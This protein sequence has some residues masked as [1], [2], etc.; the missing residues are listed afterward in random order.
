[1]TDRTASAA[2]S[3][4]RAVDWTSEWDVAFTHVK[5]RR[6]LFREYLRRA[7]L[8]ARAYGA[9]GSRPFFDATSYMDPEYR[10]TPELAA[11]LADFL[12]RLPNGEVR[13][14]CSGVVRTAGLRERN[15]AA[16]SD[17]P[18]LYEPLVLFYER[19]GEFTRDNAGFLDLT[20]VRFRPG[21]LESHLGNPPVTLLG[22]T[23]LDA[24][25]ADGQVMYHTAEGRRGP[26]FR[27]RVLRGEQS[28]E[29]F[30]RDLCWEP[31]DLIPGTGAEA[32]E[33]G[34]VRLEELEAAGLIGEIVAA[35]TR[36]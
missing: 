23:V 15:P 31:T 5:S 21:T 2:L 26:L 9:E 22:D 27:R 3:R 19:G 18:D 30:G 12:A 11:E 25:D 1:M 16:F 36:P 33:A 10:P 7:A 17:L 32:E 14:T 24:L 20:G 6:I 13:E 28:D 4:L 29:L 34:L 35:V 8:W